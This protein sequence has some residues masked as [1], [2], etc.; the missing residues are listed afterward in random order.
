[1]QQWKISFSGLIDAGCK[2]YRTEGVSGLYRGFWINSVQI[3][4]GLFYIGTYEGVRHI[5]SQYNI[6]PQIKTL[7]AGGAASLVGQ[8]IIVPFDVI[9][10]HLM[11]LGLIER[12][13]GPEKKVNRVDTDIVNYTLRH[14]QLNSIFSLRSSSYIH[15]GYR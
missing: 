8:T 9:S 12:N 11:L 6:H 1:M 5:S 3:V 7:L 15:W 14:T 10:Q 4:S 2:I 13:G